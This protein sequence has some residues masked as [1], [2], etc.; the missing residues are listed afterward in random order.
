MPRPDGADMTLLTTIIFIGTVTVVILL[1]LLH[2]RKLNEIY[3]QLRRMEEVW[4][5]RLGDIMDPKQRQIS[6]EKIERVE[7]E[8]KLPLSGENN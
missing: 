1:S 6:N 2:S 8:D 3:E 4:P 5:L 7:L